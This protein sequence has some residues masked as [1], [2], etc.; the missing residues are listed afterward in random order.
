MKK[1]ENK[2]NLILA[3][4]SPR[5]KQLLGYLNIPFEIKTADI[6]EVSNKESPEEQA[7]DISEQKGRAVFENIEAGDFLIISSDTMVIL[8]GEIFGKPGNKENARVMLNKLSGKT[9]EVV[10]AVSFIDKS[11]EAIN[12][13]DKT[14]VSFNQIDPELLEEYLDTEDSLDKAGAYGIQGA[15]LTFI[16]QIEGSY[17]NVVGFPLEKV[18]QK[19]KENGYWTKLR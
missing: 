15:S 7:C 12:F 13:F 18:I 5:R 6:D 19:L 10:T 4:G 8:D 11:G 14:K 2:L 3:S 16:S 9:H 1:R 17:S